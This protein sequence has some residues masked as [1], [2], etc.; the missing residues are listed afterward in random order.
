MI[1]TINKKLGRL[2]DKFF[3]GIF[4]LIGLALVLISIGIVCFQTF[5]YLYRGG[6][7]ALPLRKFLAYA[8]DQLYLWIVEPT[9]WIGLHNVVYWLL[10]MPLSFVCLVAGY[11]VIKISDLIALF[12]D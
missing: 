3:S 9:S 10:D 11:L 12:S 7:S 2:R 6:W 4:Y 8:P 5:N 1:G